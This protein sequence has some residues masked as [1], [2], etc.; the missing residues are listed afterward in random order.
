MKWKTKERM[1]IEKL[2]K[3]AK[4]AAAQKLKDKAFST[5]TSKEKDALL[6]RMAKDLGYL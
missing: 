6:E 2:E 3:A 1:E 5:L 4:S